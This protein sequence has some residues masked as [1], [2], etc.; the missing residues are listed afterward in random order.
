MIVLKRTAKGYEQCPTKQFDFQRFANKYSDFVLVEAA[1]EG[2]DKWTQFNLSEQE[3][4][5]LKKKKIVRLEFEEPNKF[6]LGDDMRAYDKDFSKIYTL[7]PFTSEWLNK[8]NGDSKRVPIFFPLN[9]NDVPSR[10]SKKY[11]IIYTGHVVSKKLLKDIKTMSKFNYRFVSNDNQ[12][13]VTDRSATYKNKLRL[14]SESRIAIVHNQLHPSLRHISRVWRYKNWEE[15]KAFKLIPK[16]WEWR[17]FLAL[18]GV[19]VP[20]LKSRLFEAA[21]C[22]ALI[23]C[24]RDSFNV[25]ERYFE[26]D[27]EFIYY[28]EWDL[29]E[30]VRE[31]LGNYKKYELIAE[32]A[33]QRSISNYTT[34]AFAERY[35]SPIVPT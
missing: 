32:N 12:P 24:K 21:F 4:R 28:D 26:P 11:D 23:L 30:K 7:C 9:E 6:F 33:Y 17:K 34:R 2:A 29:E 22:R 1:F 15:N 18:R 19:I 5:D 31:I 20:Q 13:L 35:F 16:W 3:L 27:T 14:I 10:C 25:I 8:K